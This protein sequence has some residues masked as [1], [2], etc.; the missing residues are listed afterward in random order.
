MGA[1]PPWSLALALAL[2]LRVPAA[3]GLAFAIYPAHKAAKLDSIESLRY[4]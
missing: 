3:V 2:A 4:E 1:I